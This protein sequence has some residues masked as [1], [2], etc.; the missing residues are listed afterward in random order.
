MKKSSYTLLITSI[1][2]I[3]VNPI[4]IFFTNTLVL[5]GTGSSI[6]TATIINIVLNAF[7]IGI[8]LS[9]ISGI[10]G[11]LAF[12]KPKRVNA[13]LI[14]G[15]IHLAYNTIQLIEFTLVG[16]PDL[17]LFCFILTSVI[18]FL[19]VILAYLFKKNSKQESI[20]ELN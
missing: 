6:S 20:E 16:A 11:I 14:I 2:M 12:R 18:P 4:L 8:F 1:L 5:M 3:I 15:S 17:A 10:L 19:Y 9:L 7:F 13:C